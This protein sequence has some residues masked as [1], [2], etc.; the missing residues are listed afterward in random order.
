MDF[1]I[2]DLVV[3]KD[4]LDPTNCL[5]EPCLARS[6]TDSFPFTPLWPGTQ[7]KVNFL[8]EPTSFEAFTQSQTSLKSTLAELIALSVAWLSEK[9]A[10]LLPSS[11]H[12]PTSLIALSV[13]WLSEK[14]AT[15]LPSS[16]HL[17]TSLTQWR[18]AATSA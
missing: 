15:L 9:I 7:A 12:L 14:I 11:V 18:I 8:W 3:P 10:T 2:C 4:E 13:A 6:S 16:V 17:P 5:A 1:L